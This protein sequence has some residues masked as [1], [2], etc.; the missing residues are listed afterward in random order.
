SEFHPEALKSVKAFM[1]QDLA[2][3]R[4]EARKLL[5]N[6]KLSDAHGDAQFLI[7]KV[8]AVAAKRWAAA[9]EA[10]EAGRYIEA[11]ETLSWFGKAFKGA[12][13]GDRAKDLLKTFKQD[14]LKREV[15]AAIKLQKLLAK[16]EGQ[17]AEVR[18]AALGKFLKDKKVEG[19]H[20][21]REAEQ[22]Q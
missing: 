5:A 21:A 15:A 22:L 20:A 19:T 10:R 17:P 16:L 2:G 8:D 12:E 14:P 3:A 7:D 18:A 6:E 13:E 4:D 1:K 9:E 11:M